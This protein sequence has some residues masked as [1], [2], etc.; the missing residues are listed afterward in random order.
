ML[1][2]FVSSNDTVKRAV[3]GQCVPFRL[4]NG[5]Q[6]IHHF[7]IVDRC[8]AYKVDLTVDGIVD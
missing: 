6:D 2:R 1:C 5:D 8:T 3:I 4:Q 7:V